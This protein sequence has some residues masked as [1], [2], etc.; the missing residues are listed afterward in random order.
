MGKDSTGCFGC[1]RFLLPS[2]A[3]EVAPDMSPG[4]WGPP[5]EVDLVPSMAR[6]RVGSWASPVPSMPAPW[7]TWSTPQDDR[8]TVLTVSGLDE[9]VKVTKTP[10]S[11]NMATA[12]PGRLKEIGWYNRD[13]FKSP[14]QGFLVEQLLASP[15][16]LPQGLSPAECKL[17]NEKRVDQVL[18]TLDTIPNATTTERLAKVPRRLLTQRGDTGQRLRR[19]ILKGATIV[20][21][22]TGYEGKRFIYERAHALGVRSVLIDSPTSWS[23]RLVD[24]GVAVKFIPIDM[25]QTSREVV[26]SC[27]AAI[28]ACERDPAVGKVDGVC[29]FAELSVPLTARLAELLGLPGPTPEATDQARDKYATRG[30]LTRYGLPTPPNC[31]IT[32]E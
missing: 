28:E 11:K 24:E 21:I 14:T 8:H 19:G 3:P 12:Q 1:F 29:T 23:K 32:C 25:D 27:L 5:A 4:S 15:G 22:T 30:A 13:G 16:S 6:P 26:K 18:K 2:N 10:T 20:F 9:P 7:G 17:Q 31:E